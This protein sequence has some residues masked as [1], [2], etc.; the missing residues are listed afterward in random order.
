MLTYKRMGQKAQQCGMQ[1]TNMHEEHFIFA[2]CVV[3]IHGACTLVA[4]PCSSSAVFKH[5][6]K[7]E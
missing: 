5:S 7:R 2:L 3:L 1:F 6:K 4:L